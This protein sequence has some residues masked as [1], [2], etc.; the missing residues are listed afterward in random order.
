MVKFDGHVDLG[1]WCVM[2]LAGRAVE[3]RA[4]GDCRDSPSDVSEARRCLAFELFTARKATEDEID[5]A[6]PAY[7]AKAD[8]L[9]AS[10]WAW[11]QRV[12][13]E[14][15]RMTGLFRDEIVALQEGA[16]AA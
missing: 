8:Q 16:L 3:R 13:G 15:D 5:A 10:D 12:A 14:L 2:A 9:V 6:L 1:N 4:F 11:I 7:Q